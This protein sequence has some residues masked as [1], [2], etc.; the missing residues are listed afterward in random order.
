M[1]SHT[2]THLVRESERQF[3]YVTDRRIQKQDDSEFVTLSPC[4][5]SAQVSSTC[6]ADR[7]VVMEEMVK[8]LSRCQHMGW[9]NVIGKFMDSKA[10]K[11]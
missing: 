10:R 9:M 11:K 4:H 6:A 5:R 2:H 3:R 8:H 7:C 1:R